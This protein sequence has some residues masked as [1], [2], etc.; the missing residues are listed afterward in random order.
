M[1]ASGCDRSEGFE[2]R[3]NQGEN[4]R[5]DLAFAIAAP[6]T[7]AFLIELDNTVTDQLSMEAATGP[8]PIFRWTKT[9]RSLVQSSRPQAAK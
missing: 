5:L 4:L 3:G 7:F 9:A 1:D 8:G 6:G 2:R